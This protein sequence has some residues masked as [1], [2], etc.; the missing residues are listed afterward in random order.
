M[1]SQFKGSLGTLYTTLSSTNPHYVRCIK[2]NAESRPQLFD[3][4]MV[5]EQLRSAGMMETI[6]IRKA[7][8]PNC[9][10]Y[11]DFCDRF[12]V[13][14]PSHMVPGDAKQ[15]TQSLLTA[16]HLAKDQW[17]CGNTKVFLK[18][19]AYHE[20]L[21]LRQRA[22]I[23]NAVKVQALT[24]MAAAKKLFHRTQWAATVFQA[25]CRTFVQQRR[26]RKARE[27]IVLIQAACRTFVQQ[28]RYHMEC[29]VRHVQAIIRMR[30]AKVWAD[31][32]KEQATKLKVNESLRV[33]FELNRTRGVC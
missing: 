12:L 14:D 32:V 25:A 3:R 28:R 13:I 9:R 27:C 15:S 17:T 18:D 6:R 11:Q 26:Y 33:L 23:K 19:G 31:K 16:L 20:L 21:E 4:K 22:L 5:E 30:A 2:P 1:G 24:R 10:L 8:F 7:G 29:A